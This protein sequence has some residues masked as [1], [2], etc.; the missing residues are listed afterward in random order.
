M[1]IRVSSV[2]YYDSVSGTLALS[3]KSPARGPYPIQRTT[4]AQVNVE[5]LLSTLSSTDTQV[6][7]WVNVIGYVENKEAVA[8]SLKHAKVQPTSYVEIK[9]IILWSAGAVRIAEYEKSLRDRLDARRE[10]AK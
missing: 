4:I 2:D 9:A 10:E 1:L 6:G 8:F 7:E 5:L 3:H